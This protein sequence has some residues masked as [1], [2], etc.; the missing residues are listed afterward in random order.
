MARFTISVSKLL[1]EFLQRSQS[2]QK[3]TIAQLNAVAG[4]LATTRSSFL[5]LREVFFIVQLSKLPPLQSFASY[6]SAISKLCL[7][8]FVTLRNIE[9]LITVR[10]L[11]GDKPSIIKLAFKFYALSW[12]CELLPRLKAMSSKKPTDVQRGTPQPARCCPRRGRSGL[13]RVEAG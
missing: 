13:F 9:W 10:I 4:A 8:A 1:V 6:C 12:L 2:G 3:D 7:M 11:N 5:W